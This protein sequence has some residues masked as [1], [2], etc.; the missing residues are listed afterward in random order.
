MR[1]TIFLSLMLALLVSHTVMAHDTWIQKRDGELVVFR[2][3]EGKAEGYDPTLVKEAKAVDAKG[4]PVAMDIKKNKEDASLSTQGTPVVVAALYD[5]GYWLKTT[6]GWKKATKREGTGKYNIVEAL[7]SKQFCKNVLTPCPEN[8]KAV[9]QLFEV[10]PLKDPMTLKVGDKLPVK[11]VMDG[12]P[13][14]GVIVANG[15]GHESEKKNPLKT[16]KDGVAQVA[17]EKKGLQ[18][19]KAS[20]KVPIKNDPDADVLHLASTVTFIVQ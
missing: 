19:V 15:G 7:K 14:E 17:I 12:K 1:K 13:V 3:H 5:S 8:T 11:V 16:D 10:V 6:E 9:G 2:G 20:H 4:T 18:L